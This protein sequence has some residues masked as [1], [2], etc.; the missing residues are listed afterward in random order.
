LARNWPGTTSAVRQAKLAGGQGV[1]WG[2]SVAAVSS[3]EVA[4][5]NWTSGIPFTN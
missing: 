5:H 3:P 1:Q 2:A 4:G